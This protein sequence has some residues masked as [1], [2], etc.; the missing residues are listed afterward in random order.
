MIPQ[1][2][3]EIGISIY[4]TNFEG[5]GGKIKT[6]PEDFLVS[7]KLSEKVTTNNK[8]GYAVYILKKRKIDTK[9]ALDGIF[10]KT[11]LRL[12]SLGL[13]DASAITEQFVC[14]VTKSRSIEGFSNQKYSIKRIGF[15]EKPLSKKEMVG[16]HFKIKVVDAS[17]NISEFSDFEKILNFYGYQRFGSSR[18][19]NHKIGKAMLFGDYAAAVNLLLSFTSKYDSDENKKLRKKFEDKLNYSKIVE[20][21][22]PQMDLEKT[23]VKQLIK[24]EDHWLAIKALPLS[25]RRFFIQAYQSFLFNKVVCMAF[26]EGEDL[27]KPK[28]GD[29]CYDKNGILGKFANDPSQRLAIPVIGYSYYKKTRFDE[30]I[31]KILK[32]EEVLPKNFFTKKMQEVSNE[33]GFRQASITCKDYSISDN[34]VQFTLSR[35]SYATIILRE[36]IKPEDPFL[37]GF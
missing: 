16:N 30:Q 5:S 34:D 11:G 17:S 37:V 35:G 25:I 32:A 12:K 3:S 7:E 2:D 26:E 4:C 6:K 22:P 15:V 20:A 10:K 19:V 29:V 24:N 23:I 31:S 18:P 1:V 33:G 9:H 21:I 8:E 13:K 14:S 36:I 28:Q 27:F